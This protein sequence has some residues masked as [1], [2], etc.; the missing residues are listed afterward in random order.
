LNGDLRR[1]PGHS[2]ADSQTKRHPRPASIA[3]TLLFRCSRITAA[4]SARSVE[5]D[6]HR[7][8]DPEKTLLAARDIGLAIASASAR[9][10]TSRRRTFA[11]FSCSLASFSLRLAADSSACGVGGQGID[12]LGAAIWR[13]VHH[14]VDWPRPRAGRPRRRPAAP[15]TAHSRHSLR[16]SRPP[17]NAGI[18]G[19]PPRQRCRPG[20]AALEPDTRFEVIHDVCA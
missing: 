4:K 5:L 6:R 18:C 10:S 11:L 17:P 2:L 16:H 15:A 19:A 12:R 13:I 8:A 7:V 20:C 14:P 1:A 9:R 3:E